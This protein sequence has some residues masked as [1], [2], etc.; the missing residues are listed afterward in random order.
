[1]PPTDERSEVQIGEAATLGGKE[2]NRRKV[3]VACIASGIEWYDFAVYGAMAVVLALVLVPPDWPGSGLVTV[4]AVFA[5]SFLARPLGAVLVGMQA[6]RRGRQDAFIATVLLMSASTAFIGL[7]PPESAT[8]PAVVVVLILLRFVQGFA[9]GGGLSTSIPFLLEAVPR[10]HWGWYGGW[11]TASVAIGIASGIAVAAAVSSLLPPAQLQT[12]GWRLPFVAALPLGLIGLY[13]RRL[14]G[15]DVSVRAAG[16]VSALATL[17]HVLA[18]HR[19]V[20][21]SGFLLVGLLSGTFNMWFVFL[22]AH[23][24]ATRVHDLSVALACSGCGLITVAVTAPLFGRL[25]DWI[26][27]R[28]VLVS[29]T[30]SLSLLVLPLFVMAGGGSTVALLA[31]NIAVGAAVGTL[32]LSAHLSE[33]FP[34]HM[35]A[36]GIALTYGLATALV[37]GTA[38]LL[39]SVLTEHVAE[40][41]VAA[42]LTILSAS[43]LMVSL[44]MPSALATKRARTAAAGPF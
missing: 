13:A 33:S 35:R 1:V 34:P 27:R 8:G 6:D 42:Y 14:L 9:S 4:F 36:T 39:G 30:G 37:G 10:R 3:L 44:R 20:V 18:T 26:G 29:G 38:P 7:L 12:W 25:S 28:R 21:A 24:V 5:T 19:H 31:A 43:G 16:Q 11:H 40:L 17:K 2:P 22:P 41:G 15:E 23:L 32:V